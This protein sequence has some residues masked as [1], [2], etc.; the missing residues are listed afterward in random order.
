MCCWSTRAKEVRLWDLEGRTERV[1]RY[2]GVIAGASPLGSC[3]RPLTHATIGEQTANMAARPD[4]TADRPMTPEELAALRLRLSRM[5]ATALLDAYFAAWMR[6]K[7]ERDSKPPPAHSSRNLCRLGRHLGRQV[8]VRILRRG[9]SGQSVRGANV[10]ST[11][12]RPHCRLLLAIPATW[13][14][15]ARPLRS[16]AF[17]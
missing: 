1:T 16:S 17:P 9:D 7:M 15:T 2:P 13:L 6:C 3:D 11:E 10:N 8:R 4:F 14:A 5:S 12:L